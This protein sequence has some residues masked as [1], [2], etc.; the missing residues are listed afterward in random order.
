M[1]TQNVIESHSFDAFFF[2]LCGLVLA[3]FR[4]HH[5]A[6][7]MSAASVEIN[8][9]ND[10]MIPRMT[11]VKMISID[12][13]HQFFVWQIRISRSI[14]SFDVSTEFISMVIYLWFIILVHMSKFVRLPSKKKNG[15]NKRSLLISYLVEVACMLRTMHMKQ[16]TKRAVKQRETETISLFSCFSLV[17]TIS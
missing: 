8:E 14:Q 4:L 6:L 17:Q 7:E 5:F 16:T 12:S 15:K 1:R 9:R 10:W 13:Q 11:T 3:F 2:V